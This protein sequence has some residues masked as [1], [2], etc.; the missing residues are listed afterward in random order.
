LLYGRAKLFQKEAEMAELMALKEG[1][2]ALVT[3]GSGFLGRAIV[4]KL[5]QKKLNVRVLC[6]KN[7]P[8]LVEKGC[9][10]F[11]GEIS[12]HKLV[13]EAVKGCDVVFHTAAKAGIEEPYSEYVRINID[14][15]EAIIKACQEHK[16]KRLVYTSS[17]S[18]VFSHGDIEGEDESLPYP[19]SHEAYYPATKAVAEQK[20]LQANNDALATVALRPHLI[21]GPGDNHLGPRLIAKAKAGKLKLVGTGANLVDTVYIDNAAQSHILAAER[22]FPGSKIGGRAYF[23]TNDD[24]KPLKEIVDG[25]LAAAGLEPVKSTIPLW[26]AFGIG[27]ICEKLWKTFQLSGEPPVTRWVAKEMA[28]AH[29]FNISAAKQDLDY[30]PEVSIEEGMKKLAAFYANKNKE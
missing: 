19:E 7:Y 5:L 6:R 24:P 12:D 29:W 13:S 18:V 23:I 20:I 28:T 14:G 2:I 22:L 17:P 16:I 25:I 26:A 15:T 27:F 4:E 8:D 30:R 21:W 10:I 3:G 1:E 11:Q 9:K